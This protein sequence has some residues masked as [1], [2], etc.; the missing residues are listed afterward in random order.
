MENES[1]WSPISAMGFESLRNDV[2]EGA[3]SPAIRWTGFLLVAEMVLKMLKEHRSIKIIISTGVEVNRE[4]GVLIE[5]NRRM[6][7]A[8]DDIT[9]DPSVSEKIIWALPFP[10]IGSGVFLLERKDRVVKE[11]L[12]LPPLGLLAPCNPVAEERFF[13]IVTTIARRMNDAFKGVTLHQN[14]KIT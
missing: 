10:S 7:V 9:A 14:M 6:T 5:I 4:D 3:A 12:G 2:A 11:Y 1:Q 13:E 8:L